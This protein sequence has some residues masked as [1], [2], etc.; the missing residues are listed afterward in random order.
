MNHSP[1]ERKLTQIILAA[2]PLGPA[3]CLPQVQTDEWHK[4]ADLA[5]QNG[6]LPL[7]YLSL[8]KLVAFD[9]LPANVLDCIREGFWRSSIRNR[10]AL[11]QL[12]LILKLFEDER[13]P[14]VVLKGSALASWLYPSE[15]SRLFTDVDILVRQSAKEQAAAI[16]LENG[17][18][19]GPR[20]ADF[21]EPYLGQESFQKEGALPIH[22][23]LHWHILD[24]PYFKERI[25]MDWFWDRTQKLEVQGNPILAFS[26]TAQLLH[27]CAHLGIHHREPRLIWSYDLALLLTRQREQINWSELAEAMRLFNL[28][29]AVQDSLRLVWESWGVGIP[30]EGKTLLSGV[31]PSS[32]ERLSAHAMAARQ[33]AAGPAWDGLFGPSLQ[34]N[35]NYWLRALFPNQAYMRSRYHNSSTPALLFLYGWRI[36][37]GVCKFAHSMISIWVGSHHA[38]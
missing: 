18:T 27:L 1:A 34:R 13:I 10:L 7:L 20:V 33:V 23:E 17:W 5:D 29:Q 12:G 22:V 26:P 35:W 31:K 36:I 30:P 11:E 19:R 21:R 3:Q 14:V 6:F 16:L 32:L 24:L 25:P 15:G 2:F 37:A 9:E 28:G 38:V 8:D 4:I